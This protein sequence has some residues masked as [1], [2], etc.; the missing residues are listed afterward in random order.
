[1]LSVLFTGMLNAPAS[2]RDD[3]NRAGRK[4]VTA[5]MTALDSEGVV[6]H[7]RVVAFAH[8]AC[9]TLVRMHEGD[10]VAIAGHLSMRRWKRGEE[11]QMGLSVRATRVMTLADAGPAPADQSIA[12]VG[13]HLTPQERAA[14]A[15]SS[16]GNA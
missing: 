1:M 3:P 4:I 2:W 7:V 11:P 9:E 16:P 5:R 6:V 13:P 14:R 8:E 10:E 12:D 15:A